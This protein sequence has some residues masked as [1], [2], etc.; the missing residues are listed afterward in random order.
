MIATVPSATLLGIDGQPVSVE[1]HIGHGLPAFSVVGL[2]DAACRESRDR[3]RAAFASTGLEFPKTRVTVNLAPSGLRKFGSGLDLAMAVAILAAQGRVDA[4]HVCESAFI[5]E[6]GLDGAVRAVPG[7]LSL[8]DA[9][10]QPAV[11]VP[12]PC[13]AEAAL[14]G[15]AVVRGISSLREV[16]S[17]LEGS[18]PWPD[19]S[20]PVPCPSPAS[21]ADLADVRGQPLGQWAVEVSAAGGHHLLLIGPPGAGKTML[22]SRLAGILPP[23]SRAQALETTRVHSAG[24]LR[25]P[26][27]GLVE[28]PPFRAPHHTASMVSLVGGGT[29]WVRPGEISF[30]TNGVLFMD[31][32]GEFPP[33]ALDTLRQPLEEGRVRVS[34]ARHTVTLPARFLLVAAMNPCPCGEGGAYGTC[35]CS[36]AARTRYARRLSGPLLDRFDLRVVL[37]RPD[38]GDLLGAPAGEASSVIAARVRAARGLAAER[39][40]RCNAEL[41]GTALERVAVLDPGARRLVE[42]R[43]RSGRLSA[44]GLHRVKRVARTLADLAGHDRGV[45]D[46]GHVAAALELRADVAV[47]ETAS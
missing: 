30:A 3:V 7:V 25:L 2:P 32:L 27:G 34:R 23:L 45:L 20:P 6:L 16:V 38:V 26:E 46:E 12:A 21:F 24:A 41:V 1:V 5:G 44:R 31:E 10:P 39:G 9:L 47:L 35:R 13:A 15:R 43:L 42:H 29:S 22:A 28:Q 36:E 33:A 40:V 4:R 37:S 17:S 18:C 19:P 11:V 14:V 8:V